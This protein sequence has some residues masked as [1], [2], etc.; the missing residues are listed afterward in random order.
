M[1]AIG[2]TLS[3]EENGASRLVAQAAR[4]EEVGFAF[5]AISDHFHPWVD[6]PKLV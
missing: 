2:Y 6:L 4:A 5:A 3:S 1:T